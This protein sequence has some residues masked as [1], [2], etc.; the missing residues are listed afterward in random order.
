MSCSR[1]KWLRKISAQPKRRRRRHGKRDTPAAFVCRWRSKTLLGLR[2]PVRAG[3]AAV[4]ERGILR[5]PEQGPQARP[6]ERGLQP[7]CCAGRERSDREGLIAF[8]RNDQRK[9]LL[10]F[11]GECAFEII[12][13]VLL[14]I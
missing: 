2:A 12:L 5:S 4:H 1:R 10:V 6:N 11:L 14:V 8:D 3:R 9:S 13:E 7:S